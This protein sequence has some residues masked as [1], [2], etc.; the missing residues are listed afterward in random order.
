MYIYLYLKL[1][2]CIK[3]IGAHTLNLYVIGTVP[4][5]LQFI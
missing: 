3:Y 4:Q 5:K 1:K 2:A